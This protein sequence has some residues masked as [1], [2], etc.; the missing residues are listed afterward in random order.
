[1]REGRVSGD[2]VEVMS[3]GCCD[4]FGEY[5]GMVKAWMG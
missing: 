5:C 2:R 4:G 3:G 1:M